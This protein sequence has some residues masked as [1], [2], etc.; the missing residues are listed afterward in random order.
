MNDASPPDL[1]R[2]RIDRELLAKPRRRRRWKWIAIAVLV[3]AAA[4][5]WAC[6]SWGWTVP[7][8]VIASWCRRT[9]AAARR[10]SGED[11]RPRRAVERRVEANRLPVLPR[12]PAAAPELGQPGA[13]GEEAPQHE[14]NLNVG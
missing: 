3:I 12:G 11:D 4:G 8:C 14:I 10:L 5:F 2:L 6:G 7:G 13:A 1:A 9:W